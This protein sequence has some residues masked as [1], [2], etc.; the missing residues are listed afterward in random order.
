[1]QVLL[2]SVY[3][4]LQQYHTVSV[5]QYTGLYFSTNNVK[6]M[7]K[8]FFFALLT[9]AAWSDNAFAQKANVKMQ[10]TQARLVNVY[11]RGYVKPLTVELKVD[12]SKGRITRSYPLTKEETEVEMGGS[13]DNI[14]SYAVYMASQEYHADAIVAATFNFRTNDD[15]KGYTITITGYPA[16]FVNWKTASEADYEWIRM[17]KTLTTDDLNRISAIIKQKE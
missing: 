15:G 14:R 3:L 4:S 6:I 12:D 5:S 10:D 7:K 2:H 13:L 17:E 11:S 8:L 9:L 16:S 1:M